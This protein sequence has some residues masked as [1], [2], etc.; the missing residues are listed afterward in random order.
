MTSAAWA[1]LLMG[2]AT[3]L[4]LSVIGIV[5]GVTLGLVI[6]IARNAKLILFSRFLALYVSLVR[7][8]PLI[9]LCLIISLGLPSLGVDISAV[10]AAILAMTIN[11]SAFQSEVWRSGFAAFPKDQIEAA[12]SA[13]LSGFQRMRLILLPQVTRAVLPNLVNEMTVLVKNSPAI[14]ILGIV[15]ITRAAVRIGADTFDPLPPLLSALALYTAIV[16]LLVIFQRVQERH[17]RAVYT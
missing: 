9:T 12:K 2:A 11:T 5:L 7:A 15:D 10:A 6:A 4:T 8:T 17:L 13:G 3:T 14:A 16:F 1:T